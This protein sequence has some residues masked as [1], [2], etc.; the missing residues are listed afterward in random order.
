MTLT[1][2][3]ASLAIVLGLTAPAGAVAVNTEGPCCAGAG[4]QAYGPPQAYPY[5]PRVLDPRLGYYGT[6]WSS[7]Q[8][9]R[10]APHK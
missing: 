10:V 5:P 8:Q 2:Y 9:E 3:T 6:Y 4:W 7:G 1:K